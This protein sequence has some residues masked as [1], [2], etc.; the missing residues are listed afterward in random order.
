MVLVA[1]QVDLAGV[2]VKYCCGKYDLI[3]ADID[4]ALIRYSWRTEFKPDFEAARF[5]RYGNRQ[6]PEDENEWIGFQ[7]WFVL[8]CE[9]TSGEAVI[10]R[11][12]EQY[13]AVMSIDVRRLLLGWKD[14]IDGFLG[15]QAKQLLLIYNS[16]RKTTCI[17][18]S[19][20]E[21]CRKTIAAL[22]WGCFGNF[23]ESADLYLL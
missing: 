4:G 8:E 22:I 23:L 3:E 18:S 14:V 12:I 17:I 1:Y 19:H 9:L 21:E 15:I 5:M 11:F 7:D 6:R 13:N 10:Y 16:G 20:Y 2:G